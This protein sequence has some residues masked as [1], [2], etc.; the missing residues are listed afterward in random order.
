MFSDERKS[1]PQTASSQVASSQ[2]ASSQT[3]DAAHQNL[4][5]FVKTSLVD[6]VTQQIRTA[7]F[8]GKYM[9]GQKLIVRELSE[10]MGVS[11][12]PVK[13]ALNRLTAEGLVEAVPNRSMV[14]REFTNIELIE[15][16]GVRLMCEV[17]FA[18]EIVR[19]TAADPSIITDM[20][21]SLAQMRT[22]IKGDDEID[23]ESWVDAETCFHRRYIAACPNS[24][25]QALY[26]S[27]DSNRFTYFAFLNN[28]RMPLH[29]ETLDKNIVEHE[30]I[31]GAL[32]SADAAAFQRA[33]CLHIVRACDDY[34]E[35]AEAEEKI[36]EIKRL[37]KKYIA[38]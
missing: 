25:M 19:G 14:V 34:A 22:T 30:A 15:N 2:V 8:T 28:R 10:A 13:D 35:S 29:R 9:P 37:A 31:I 32:S 26:A 7:I 11:H 12:T 3:G 20:E 23:Y 24:R 17:F 27:L 1:S 5:A 6:L 38:S 16:L 21:A 36:Q 18:E 33:V 4:S